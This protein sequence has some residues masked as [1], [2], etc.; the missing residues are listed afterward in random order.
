MRK[1]AAL[2]VQTH[3]DREWYL[4]NE[5]YSARLLRVF[6]TILNALD[7]GQI[8][9]FLFD[10]QTAALEDL[11]AH[12]EKQIAERTCAY[13]R[14][15]KI[16]IGPWYAMPDE[17]LCAGESLIRNLEEGITT[18]K[19]YGEKNF[20]GY[21]PD[22]FGHVAQMPQIF[23]GF[24]IEHAVVWRGVNIPSDLFQW[25]SPNG[26]SVICLFLPEGYYQQP[27]SKQN[28]L[29][30]VQSY[31]QKVEQDFPQAGLLLTQGGDHLVP[32]QDLK[33]RI[34]HF[35]Q[36]QQT[37]RVKQT[38]LQ[39]HINQRIAETKNLPILQGELRDNTNSYILPDV[40]STR[41]YLKRH[42]QEL[43]DRLIGQIEP[44]LAAIDNFA[45][46]Y[47]H[48]YLRQTWQLLLQQHAHD[49]ICGCSIDAVHA[50]MLVRF[51]RIKDR[52]NALQ[53]LACEH[54]GLQNP[55]LNTQDPKSPSP[56]ADDTK[57]TAFNPSL[58]A[59]SGWHYI[60]FFI[61]GDPIDNLKISDTAG[62]VYATAIVDRQPH[63]DFTSPIDD[64]PEHVAGHLYTAFIRMEME[65]WASKNL[66]IVPT[67]TLPTQQDNQGT[68]ATH[69]ISNASMT[70]AADKE[71]GIVITNHHN[72]QTPKQ[73]LAIISQ[74][75]AGDSYNYSPPPNN[76]CVK[77]TITD[78][79]TC[80][81]E[82]QYQ[83]LRINFSLEQPASLNTTR[84]GPSKESV[85][86]KGH[87]ILRLLADE[88]FIRAKLTWNNKAKNH[89]LRLHLPLG[90]NIPSS[91]SDSAFAFIKRPVTYR[92]QR[93]KIAPQEIPPCVHPS[94]SLIQA[95]EHILIHRAL[96]EYEIVK[97]AQGD[98][99]ALTLSRSV[100]W[101]S[102]RDLID[103]GQGAGPDFATPE[104]QC[105]GEDYFEFVLAN[106]HDFTPEQALA[107]AND[108]RRPIM[109][110]RGHGQV[111]NKKLQIKADTVIIF[112]CR[113]I[114]DKIEVRLFNPSNAPQKFAIIGG[115]AERV[116]LAG[117]SISCIED[118][119]HQDTQ[120][121]Q[122]IAPHEIVTL[123][124]KQ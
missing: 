99:L 68:T 14:S 101:L 83:E 21:L 100:G 46:Q 71:N 74:G 35:N 24:G 70:I 69:S 85:T 18:S 37:Y 1:K 31:F 88:P 17:N 77:A 63:R 7:T 114:E 29:E 4:T 47:P 86:S 58:K 66:I 5:E 98:T 48:R 84:S 120:P 53:T 32:P 73:A 91:H 89:R 117:T 26:Q 30:A 28:Y 116:T 49:S 67:K 19:S 115:T 52:L 38:T 82:K 122:V 72:S 78:I 59:R 123:R 97:G 42:N 80:F 119:K 64:F 2:V 113:K 112:S 81:I 25:Q 16:N 11:M 103:R 44:L 10:G 13:I 39:D 62:T 15:G 3:W 118:S 33:N 90:K 96:N 65:G 41:R 54:I 40:L 50:E 109:F 79:K 108:L 60:Q 61:S 22:T 121:A 76:W 27:F 110:L 105:L 45:P 57:I 36:A 56:F 102:R 94:Y 92:Q 43:E 124:I 75:D 95:G 87:L 20:L 107:Q 55:Y 106:T 93:T 34:T 8:D 12:C 104:A 111:S 51:H 23:A 6:P 9:R